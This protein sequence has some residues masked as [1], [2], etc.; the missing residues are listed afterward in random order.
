MARTVQ[1]IDDLKALVSQKKGVARPNV[2]AVALPSI[3]GLRSRELNLLCSDVN[4]PGRQIMTQERDIG[5]ITQKVANNQAYDDVSLTFRCLN[6]YGIREYFEAWQN[7]CIDQSSLEVGY[8]NEYSFNVKIH[9]LARG[10]GAP[11]YQTPFGL[12][13]LPPMANAVIDQFIGATPLGGVV[14]ALKGELDLGFIG[15]SDTVYSCELLQAFP[16]TMSSI[17]LSD[18]SMDGTVNLTVQLSYKNW[19]S[20]KQKGKPFGLNQSG[21]VGA[22]GNFIGGAI[23]PANAP[24]QLVFTNSNSSVVGPQ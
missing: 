18:G 4:L 8:L 21:L 19:R 10:F 5:L 2:F 20:S 22:V 14:N 3:A 23:R 11:T 24:P 1:T 13:K 6:D 17:Q 12:P 15:Q 9:Q 16:T 7:L